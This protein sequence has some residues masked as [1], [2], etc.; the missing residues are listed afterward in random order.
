MA[1]SQSPL[2]FPPKEKE[3][4]IGSDIISIFLIVLLSFI[5]VKGYDIF[6]SNINKYYV[7]DLGALSD[8]KIISMLKK[9]EASWDNV[10]QESLVNEVD[11]FKEQLADDLLEASGGAPVFHRGTVITGNI[12]IIDLTEAIAAKHSLVLGQSLDSYLESRGRQ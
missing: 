6:F 4:S 3:K 1:N 8:A 5:A 7:A 12:S 10:N 2:V 11:A 9:Y